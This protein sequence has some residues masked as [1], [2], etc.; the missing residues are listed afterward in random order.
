MFVKCFTSVLLFPNYFQP[1]LS[2]CQIEGLDVPVHKT[3]VNEAVQFKVH[4]FAIDGKPCRGEHVVTAIETSR[5]D[6][7]ELLFKNL[8]ETVGVF[9]FIS[10][11]KLSGEYSLSVFVNDVQLNP[12]PL[13]IMA[14]CTPQLSTYSVRIP[15]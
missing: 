2:K 6:S 5:S 4:L 11:P 1:D 7:Q 14:S 12:K 13:I 10:T 3:N 15:V 9:S 8:D